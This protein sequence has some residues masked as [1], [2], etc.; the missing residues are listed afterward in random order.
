[1]S[2][3]KKQRI[4]LR[5]TDDD[6]SMIEEAAAISN[7]SVSQFMLNSA[8]QRAAE[9]IE[10]HRRV[11]LNEESWTRVMDALSNPLSPGEKLKRAVKRLQGM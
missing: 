4:D 7:Q 2:A 8:S 5:L 10:Q 1:M 11:I 6:K 9:V 3:V